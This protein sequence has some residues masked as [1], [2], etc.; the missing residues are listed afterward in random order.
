MTPPPRTVGAITGI[1]EVRAL[2]GVVGVYIEVGPGDTIR[3]AQLARPGRQR[4]GPGGRCRDGGLPR[5]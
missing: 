2:P 1:D 5:G 3:G 4:R